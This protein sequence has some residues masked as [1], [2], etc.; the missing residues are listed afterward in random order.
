MGNGTGGFKFTGGERHFLNLE[1]V[2]SPGVRKQLPR[3]SIEYS[4]HFISVGNESG[5]FKNTGGDRPF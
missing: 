5:G 4:F 2:L 1:N 3:G